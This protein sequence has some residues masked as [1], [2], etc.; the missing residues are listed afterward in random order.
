M[1]IEDIGPK[2]WQFKFKEW[3]GAAPVIDLVGCAVL[4]AV[5]GWYLISAM[6]LPS[7]LNETDIGAG[8]FP[9]LLAI[10]TLIAI[11]AVA[12][13]AVIRLMDLG[14][15][16]APGFCDHRGCAD[17]GRSHLVRSAWHDGLRR[18]LCLRHDAG[19]R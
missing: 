10:G 17:G 3:R 4:L 2:G 12:V 5:F 11:L 15:N 14:V 6:A 19:L 7:P 16:S 13:S 18:R 1:D 8:G 9:R